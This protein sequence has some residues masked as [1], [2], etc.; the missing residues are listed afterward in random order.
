MGEEYEN[1][2]IMRPFAHP[3]RPKFY[4]NFILE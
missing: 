3:Q 1:C 2:I 4:A